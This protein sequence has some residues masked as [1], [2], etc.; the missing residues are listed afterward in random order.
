MNLEY[1]ND[2]INYALNN[3]ILEKNDNNDFILNDFK[4]HFD[5]ED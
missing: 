4:Y 2:L 3:G 1:A 5:F